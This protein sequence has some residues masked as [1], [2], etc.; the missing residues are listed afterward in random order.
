[1]TN[2]GF[3]ICFQIVSEATWILEKKLFSIQRVCCDFLYN[4]CQKHFI[5]EEHS[6]RY[7]HKC[8]QLWMLHHTNVHISACCTVHRT[9]YHKCPQ[10]LCMLHHLNLSDFNQTYIFYTRF[11]I[12]LKCQVSL[13]SVQWE[14]KCAMQADTDTDCHHNNKTLFANAPQNWNLKDC[15]YVAKHGGSIHFSP[16]YYYTHIKVPHERQIII[17]NLQCK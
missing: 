6:T 7:Y 4:F 11:R 5:S 14:L 2:A 15:K 3:I 8:P 9:H 10:Q 12:I 17:H 1:M 16:R 13:K